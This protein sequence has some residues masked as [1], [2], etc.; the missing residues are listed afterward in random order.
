VKGNNNVEN[1]YEGND[2]KMTM[3]IYNVMVSEMLYLSKV[4]SSIK[5]EGRK[6]NEI[7]LIE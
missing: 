7:M 1:T 4:I 3:K 5:Y 6:K 2:V